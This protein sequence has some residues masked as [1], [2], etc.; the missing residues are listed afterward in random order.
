MEQKQWI[1]YGNNKTKCLENNNKTGYYNDGG[2]AAVASKGGS[3]SKHN[4]ALLY[5]GH[6]CATSLDFDILSL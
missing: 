6:V 2:I 3:K 1:I 5:W 4:A